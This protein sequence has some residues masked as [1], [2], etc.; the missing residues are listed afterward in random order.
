MRGSRRRFL[1]TGFLGLIGLGAAVRSS[2]QDGAKP[3]VLVV[4][5]GAF[6][7]WTALYLLRQGARVTLVDAWGPGNSR[8]SS[9][10]ETRNITGDYGSPE[11]Y[12]NW[13]LRAMPL[14][15]EHQKQ[16]NVPL[17]R[18]TGALWMVRGSLGAGDS[19][20]DRTADYTKWVDEDVGGGEK[21]T[22]D[23][24][25][26][27]FPQIHFDGI[28][29]TFYEEEAGFLMARR[30]CRAVL[31]GFSAEGGIYR[32]ATVVSTQIKGGEMQGVTLGDGS[33]IEAGRYVFACGP[34][35]GKLF[36]DVVGPHL[37]ITRQEVYYLETPEGDER[38]R[39]GHLPHWV[40]WG[41]K[42]WWGV[43]A[44]QQWGFTVADH[45]LGPRFDPT[46]GDRQI[47]M[48]AMEA[49]REHVG[50]RFPG[51]KGAPYIG[52]RVCQ[53]TSTPDGDYIIDRHPKAENA[54]ITGG[55]SGTGFHA[56]P[57]R[58]QDVARY[59]LGKGTPDP[60][61]ALARFSKNP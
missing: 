23:E 38:F 47:T 19:A 24:A 16:W 40:D 4:G 56:G 60:R 29:T 31:D 37:T 13:A 8:S 12:R 41:E 42:I 33:R 7:G 15:Q 27:R 2:G 14:W 44:H 34:W 59:V 6:G 3:R 45:R 53:Y 25:H 9:G 39:E 50:F 35:L 22:P 48:P 17:Y 1:K 26:A 61:F 52:G 10:G 36:P 43:P 21:L 5:A 58:G 49:A 46:S 28:R 11:V 55:G 51:M 54:W 18:P 20:T 57:A 32:Q 30:A